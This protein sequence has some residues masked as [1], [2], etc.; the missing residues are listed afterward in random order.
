MYVPSPLFLP[1]FQT[2]LLSSRWDW[3]WFTVGSKACSHFLH[4]HDT[5]EGRLFLWE[6]LG[7]T[8]VVQLGI[9]SL[10][11]QSACIVIF[12]RWTGADTLRFTYTRFGTCLVRIILPLRCFS[13]IFLILISNNIKS[14]CQSLADLQWWTSHSSCLSRFCRPRYRSSFSPGSQLCRTHLCRTSCPLFPVEEARSISLILSTWWTNRQSLFVSSSSKRSGPV[15]LD[16]S[17]LPSSEFGS[18]PSP[19]PERSMSLLI[20]VSFELSI[21]VGRSCCSLGREIMIYWVECCCAS[22]GVKLCLPSELIVLM[23]DLWYLSC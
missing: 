10:S 12:V 13:I 11:I 21:R 15:E 14:L 7:K 6:N 3:S 19:L 5:T 8:G 23:P 22:R 17:S 20:P 4:Y 16:S 2:P 1:S 18:S 9:V